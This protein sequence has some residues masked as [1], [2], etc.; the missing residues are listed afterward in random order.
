M[1]VSPSALYSKERISRTNVNH[2]YNIMDRKSYAQCDTKFGPIVNSRSGI[3]KIISNDAHTGKS[4]EPLTGKPSVTLIDFNP[5]N[6]NV[7]CI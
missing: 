4:V 5:E 1:R 2:S 3:V 6:V 7:N